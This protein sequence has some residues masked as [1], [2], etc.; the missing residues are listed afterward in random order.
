MK[1]S[2]KASDK[3][4]GLSRK[5]KPEDMSLEQ[6]QRTLRREF[7]RKQAFTFE[8][9]GG[10]PVFS[11][12]HV[13]NPTTQRTYRVAIRGV[14]PGDNYCS[15]PDFETNTLGTCKHIEWVLLQIESSEKGRR[16]LHAGCQTSY[17]EVYL[18]Y[19]LQRRVMLN[20]GEEG[21]ND[22]E[23]MDLAEKHFAFDLKKAGG[24]Q[25]KDRKSFRHGTLRPESYARFEKFV[26]QAQKLVSD[27][28][29][30]DDALTFVAQLRDETERRERI[31]QKF[32][33][34]IDSLA[35]ERLLKV[36]LYPYQREGALFVANAGRSLLADDMGL[37]KTVQA[38]AA[39][40]ILAQVMGVER[41]L[42]V[43]PTSLKHQW[44]REIEK[45]C[46]HSAQV[47]E[48]RLDQRAECYKANT[49]FKITN[50]DVV[51]RDLD[52]I[53]GWAP[54][55][56][57]LDEAQR[58]KNWQTK[59]AQVVKKLESEYAIVLTGTP[60]EN[61]LEELHSIVE[62]VDRF[63]L[64]P[65]FRFLSEHEEI[66]DNGQVI[67]YRNLSRISQTLQP[68]LLRRHKDEVLRQLPERM[69]KN[70][71]VPMTKEQ[72]K[73]HDENCD[74][75]AR[76]V[77]KW[78]RMGFLSEKDQRVLMISLQ[79]MR[80]SCNSTYL[81]DKKTDHS[82]KMDELMTYLLETWETPDT[83]VVVFS[84][85]TR[86]H[87]LILRRFESLNG[88][89]AFNHVFL[90]G[91]IPG[92]DRKGLIEQ[93]HK[94]PN[95][96]VFLSTDAGGVGLNLQ[97][98]S[99]VVNM[100][101]PWNPAVL[102]QRIGRVHRLGQR[103]PVHVANFISEKTI[104]ERMLSVLGFKKSMFAGVL[105]GGQD[106][107]FLGGSKLKRFMETVEKV[108]D[109]IES[110]VT[111]ETD[112][113]DLSDQPQGERP[114]TLEDSLRELAAA[115]APTEGPWA[116]VIAVGASFIGQLSGAL[117]DSG[118]GPSKASA[119]VPPESQES[120]TRASLI[121]RDPETGASFLRI[122]EI[123]QETVQTFKEAFAQIA[124]EFLKKDA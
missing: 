59:T 110:D 89:R 121:V 61:R 44:I 10:H 91:G 109:S 101:Q 107:V 6:W 106:E 94:D 15:C 65:R 8:N 113:T 27:L 49:F 68:I 7:G 93:F 118:K 23:F 92:K 21:G 4:R 122:P 111:R 63:N 100:D 88:G 20:P 103:K 32:P 26:K 67:G 42:I 25:K 78:R 116:E 75:V 58:I 47:I 13:T 123:P 81:L 117:Q 1:K 41:V 30:Y 98:A 60:L 99:V 19:G 79:N 22:S 57:I 28:R 33:Q 52:Y 80:M 17:A 3:K 96:R 24:R 69:D 105:D 18:R 72:W 34:G 36:S 62:F 56:I 112:R 29:V 51:R 53:Q 108:S 31:A 45:F 77:A 64:G 82:V 5:R 85:W 90:H 2:T 114:R 74:T 16:A 76:I 71:F 50:Y 87:E 66:G 55:V 86:T 46:V 12:Y 43:S 95:C 35:F 54:D 38:I 48:G 124:S 40:E 104:E 73:H 9:I 14:C 84:Q 102:E 97:C 39:V 119:D 11:E 120:K 115:I 83:K 70:F 37:G